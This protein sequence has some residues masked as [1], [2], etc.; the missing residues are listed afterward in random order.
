MGR[1]A[2]TE[3]EKQASKLRRDAKRKRASAEN[4]Q[5]KANILKLRDQVENDLRMKVNSVSPSFKEHSYDEDGKRW[6]EGISLGHGRDFND[7]GRK[8][9]VVSATNCSLC[10]RYLKF[11]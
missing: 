6:K 1:R 3:E 8:F 4:A 11:N 10:Y 5:K 7:I 2:H 9:G